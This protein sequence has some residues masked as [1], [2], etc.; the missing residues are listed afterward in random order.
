MV[1]IDEQDLRSVDGTRAGSD[2]LAQDYPSGAGNA[3]ASTR[4]RY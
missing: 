1:D 4:A 3:R 2:Q